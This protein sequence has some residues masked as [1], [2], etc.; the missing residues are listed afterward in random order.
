MANRYFVESELFGDSEPLSADEAGEIVDDWDDLP[1][2]WEYTVEEAFGQL[3]LYADKYDEDA[4]P[5]YRSV[6]WVKITPDM[7]YHVIGRD[8]A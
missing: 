4:E 8:R 5:L 6:M 7:Y 3:R 2:G 1:E